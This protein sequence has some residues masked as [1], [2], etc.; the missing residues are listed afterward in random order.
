MSNPLF[1]GINEGTTEL[2][3][4]DAKIKLNDQAVII[5]DWE[6][7]R[8]NQPLYKFGSLLSRVLLP[9]IGVTPKSFIADL[10]DRLW[11]NISDIPAVDDYLV[12]AEYVLY[13]IEMSKNL[14]SIIY[15]HSLGCI[16]ALKLAYDLYAKTGVSIPVVLMSPPIGYK[17]FHKY[18]VI[19]NPPFTT[20]SPVTMTFGKFDWLTKVIARRYMSEDNPSNIVAKIGDIGHSFTEHTRLLSGEVPSRT[21]SL[22]KLFTL[23]GGSNVS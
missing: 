2:L 6:E 3:S 21:L 14:P 10:V 20:E 13:A 8:D 5:V 17:P 19:D 22:G 12:S 16:P 7:W 18:F 4:E 15:G 23:I 1:L 9:F 11:D